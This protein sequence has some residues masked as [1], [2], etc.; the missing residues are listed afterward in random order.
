M[1]APRKVLDIWVA[2]ILMIS[3]LLEVYATGCR[4]ERVNDATTLSTAL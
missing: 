4:F 3:F 2:A 1:L